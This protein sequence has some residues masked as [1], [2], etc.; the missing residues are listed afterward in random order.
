MCLWLVHTQALHE[1]AILLR[2]Q[3]SC[4]AFFPGPLKGTGLQ[5]FIQQEKSVAFPVQGFDSVSAPATEK[6]QRIAERVQVKLLLNHG[7][8]AVNSTAQVGIAALSTD[9][10]NAAYPH[11]IFILIFWKRPCISMLFLKR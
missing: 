2:C 7:G 6:K 8:Q 10:N 11:H 5:S 3:G 9:K 1:P 4:F